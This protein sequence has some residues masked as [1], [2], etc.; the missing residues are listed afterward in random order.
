MSES[1]CVLAIS[2]SGIFWQIIPAAMCIIVQSWDSVVASI[3]LLLLVYDHFIPYSGELSHNRNINYEW[4][5]INDK[6]Q[7]WVWENV[8][9]GH[10]S[11][12]NCLAN[13]Y[14]SYVHY[15]TFF[16]DTKMHKDAAEV[17]NKLPKNNVKKTDE[18]KNSHWWFL[19]Q[20]GGYS[21]IVGGSVTTLKLPL[22][23]VYWGGGISY[24]SVTN[25]LFLVADNAAC[26]FAIILFW[27]MT[28][29]SQLPSVLFYVY[30][31]P[32]ETKR[33]P[34]T[35]KDT[36]KTS[37]T[38][39][40]KGRKRHLIHSQW[41]TLFFEAAWPSLCLCEATWQSLPS[42]TVHTGNNI[43]FHQILAR[44]STLVLTDEEVCKVVTVL[45]AKNPSTLDAGCMVRV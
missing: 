6:L 35:E 43:E 18:G 15:C 42:M 34:S 27:S 1:I 45:R 41:L 4:D 26:I 29:K 31:S 23:S 2:L 19:R 37:K 20:G 14:I 28:Q 32:P 17:N 36:P 8:Y 3:S 12:Q 16:S 24:W 25:F 38:K 22:Q 21:A 33:A 10:Y 13:K 9:F 7:T 40:N 39:T 44:L 5:I 11:Q 30:L